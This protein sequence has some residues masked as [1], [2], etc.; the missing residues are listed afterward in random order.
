MS[1]VIFLYTFLRLSLWHAWIRLGFLLWVA[2][3]ASLIGL[4]I[5]D[6]NLASGFARLS[7]IPIA[8]IGTL[9]IVYLAIR[10]QD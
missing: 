5:I 1:I 10:G 8:A 3:Q 7:F 6:A 9:L 2:A 4:A